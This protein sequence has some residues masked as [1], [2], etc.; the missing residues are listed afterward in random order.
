MGFSDKLWE[1]SKYVHFYVS[2]LTENR[3]GTIDPQ[4]RKE[5]HN[6]CQLVVKPRCDIQPNFP[7]I[8]EALKFVKNT[9]A[10]TRYIG[11]KMS[12]RAKSAKKEIFSYF[13]DYVIALRVKSAEKFENYF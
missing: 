9:A 1:F 8:V 4:R 5:R 12:I 3:R 11:L 2:Q 13:L 10:M 7:F 6:H